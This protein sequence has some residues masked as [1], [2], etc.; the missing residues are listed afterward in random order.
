MPTRPGSC[1]A[2]PSPSTTLPEPCET[3]ISSGTFL[4]AVVGALG[5]PVLTS[6]VTSFIAL[7]VTG[8]RLDVTVVEP[9]PIAAP[10]AAACFSC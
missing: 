10:T 1:P 7:L 5:N 8:L 9:L 6:N 4:A 2:H 3:A